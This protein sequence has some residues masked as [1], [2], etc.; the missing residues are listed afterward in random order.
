MT[1]IG[2]VVGLVAWLVT[3]MAAKS[4]GLHTCR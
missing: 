3:F 1:A 2:A 4:G